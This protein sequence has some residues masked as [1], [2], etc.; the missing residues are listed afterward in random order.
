MI[1]SV[2]ATS[3][4]GQCC[5]ILLASSF[6]ALL[7]GNLHAQQ[8]SQPDHV[9][10]QPIKL[11]GEQQQLLAKA[12]AILKKTTLPAAEQEVRLRI[13]DAAMAGTVITP[14]DDNPEVRNPNYWAI[15]KGACVVAPNSTASEA[16]SDL[17]IVHENDG[18]PVPRIWCYKYALLIMVEGYIQYFRDTGNTAG[19]TAIDNLIAH[20]DFPRDLPGDTDRL[21]WTR[22]CGDDHL[23]PGDQVWFENPYFESGKE[24]IR[25]EAFRDAIA[26][27][28]SAQEAAA[29]AKDTVAAYA[30]GEEGSNIFYLGDQ[31]FVRGDGRPSCGCFAAVFTTAG[32]LQPT[33]SRSSRRRFSRS[34]VFSGT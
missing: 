16:I 19:L 32:N 3:D 1:R 31:R 14:D 23:L 10:G 12:R 26:A 33:T 13:L 18:V 34:R 4:I 20:G 30:A 5:F 6:L 2:R 24:L 15:S 11:T 7:P 22:R 17:W 29:S 9:R 8:S 25:Q 28:K 27:G 21:L